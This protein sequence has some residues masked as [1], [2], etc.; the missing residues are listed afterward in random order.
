MHIVLI[1]SGFL[2]VRLSYVEFVSLRSTVHN[3]V[4]LNIKYTWPTC[5][6]PHIWQVICNM[7]KCILEQEASKLFESR[8]FVFKTIL[9]HL[10]PL[11]LFSFPVSGC[12]QA[13]GSHAYEEPMMFCTDQLG[14]SRGTIN[15]SAVTLFYRRT[16][17]QRGPIQP[18]P[19]GGDGG[20]L[21]PPPWWT[22]GPRLCRS[23]AG[24]TVP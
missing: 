13:S 16:L 15:T 12:L 5:T 18:A 19:R 6:P 8:I 4:I 7:L 14:R 21:T 22:A 17:N 2:N 1:T 23:P 11:C 9:T 3:P 20:G 10:C 24:F